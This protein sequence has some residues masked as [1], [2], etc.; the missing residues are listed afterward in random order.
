LL[1][2]AIATETQRNFITIK[3]PELLSKWVGE[4]E[5]GVR[6]VFRKARMAAPSILF[7]DEVDALIPLRGS[8]ESDARVTEKVIS[9]FLTEM[10]GIEVLGDVIVLAATN[11]PDLLD[12]AILRAGRF[13]ELI[14]LPLPDHEARKRILAVHNRK[15]PLRSD[16]DLEEL[17]GLTEGFAGSELAS[18]VDRALRLAIEE[19]I[20]KD[21]GTAHQPPFQ[22]EIRRDHYLRAL[23]EYKRLG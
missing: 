4:S 6:E 1:A 15:R 14:E 5:K 11:R 8:G 9:Q 13:D 2:K 10:D 19:Y 12:P 16:V 23:G 21:P 7:F 17:A 20:H 22:I 3:G 18:L